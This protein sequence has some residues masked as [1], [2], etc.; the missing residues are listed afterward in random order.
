MTARGDAAYHVPV[1]LDAVLAAASGARRA[2]DA[3]LGDGGHA[4][5]LRAAGIEVL[6]IDR[7]PVAIDRARTRLGDTGVRYLESAYAAP[8]A[9]AVVAEFA[10]DFVLLDLGVSSRQF[11]EE[12]RGF[13]FRP[14][15]PLDMRMS[16]SGETAADLL[17]EAPDTELA[18]ILYEYGDERRSRPLAREIVRR[19]QREPFRISDDL[20]NA[21]R[22]VLGPRSGPGDFAR[23]FQALRIAVNDELDG[24]SR[25]LPAFRDALTAGGTLAVISY[26]SGEDRLVKHQFREWARDC[27][28][29]PR[30]PVCT[31]DV[32]AFGRAEP[33]RPIVP[34][35]AEIAANPRA[36]S[37]RLRLFRK[38]DAA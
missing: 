32:R 4:E 10:P 20:V 6:G 11:D 18:R 13:T 27:I 22:A 26:H 5:A 14:G 36:R 7:D 8:A 15:A 16:G 23:S 29:P 31:C 2:V 33:R 21:I 30:Q 34:D 37:A 9:L 38:A 1:L 19:R 3:T 24:L 25:A 17:N 12:A 28:C 35:D